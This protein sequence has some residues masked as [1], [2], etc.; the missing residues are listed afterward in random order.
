MTEEE[1]TKKVYRV[2][3]DFVGRPPL[4]NLEYLKGD[5]GIDSVDVLEAIVELEDEF[6]I[7]ISDAS[8][9]E[10]VGDVIELIKKELSKK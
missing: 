3:G 1:T 8:E 2:I 4:T 5:L 9:L 6:D 10:T 7:V